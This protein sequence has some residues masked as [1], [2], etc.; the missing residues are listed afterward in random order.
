MLGDFKLLC[1]S[2]NFCLQ[3]WPLRRCSNA[4]QCT[5]RCLTQ[6]TSL[7]RHTHATLPVVC[8]NQFHPKSKIHWETQGGFVKGW[9][10]RMYPRSGFLLGN[11]RKYPR[12][13]FC[14]ERTSECT[15]VQVFVPGEHPPK[16][17]FWKPPFC[18]PPIN[19]QVRRVT[20]KSAR[21]F[22]QVVLTFAP[23]NASDFPWFF[24]DFSCFVSLWS[25]EHWK[26]T[27]KSQPFFT[28]KISQANQKNYSHNV[29]G[30]QA[31]EQIDMSSPWKDDLG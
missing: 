13:G 23:K 30:E 10:W 8:H 4:Q 17:P 21:I 25:W 12:S 28:A 6:G 14:S 11:M 18:Q 5:K 2:V 20:K 16:P 24:D 3:C 7:C 19:W 29:C 1:T 9:F 31:I 26:L 27:T 22:G 15:L